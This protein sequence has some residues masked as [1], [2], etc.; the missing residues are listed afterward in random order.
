MGLVTRNLQ[1]QLNFNPAIELEVSALG[2]SNPHT[3]LE[4]ARKPEAT[5]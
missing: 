2:Q 5:Q 4:T 1:E 3:K